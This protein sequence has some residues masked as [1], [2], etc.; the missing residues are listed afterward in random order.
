MTKSYSL[1]RL[2]VI[3]IL[4]PVLFFQV[5]FFAMMLGGILLGLGPL[6]SF[7]WFMIYISGITCVISRLRGLR[8]I[9]CLMELAFAIGLWIIAV[10]HNL[11]TSLF[12]GE[13]DHP[14][15]NFVLASGFVL[16]ITS[17]LSYR[18]VV[19][20]FTP[21]LKAILDAIHRFLEIPPDENLSQATGGW[22]DIDD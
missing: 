3:G 22:Q 18:L 15:A 21:I 12:S 5:Y 9:V 13:I 1:K 8:F 11:F 4:I 19:Y 14:F 16:G 20:A 2:G 17:V 6:A 7:I 10:N